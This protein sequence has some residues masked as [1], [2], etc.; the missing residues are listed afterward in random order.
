MALRVSLLLL[1]ASFALAQEGADA[2]PAVRTTPYPAR[3][4]GKK[5]ATVAIRKK[6]YS[7]PLPADWV[8]RDAEVANA[9][10]AWSVLLPGSTETAELLLVRDETLASP[11][12]APYYHKESQTWE[13]ETEI[14]PSPVPRLIVTR[15]GRDWMNSYVFFAFRNN[16]Y[17]FQLSCADE[18]FVEAEQD[19]IAAAQGFTAD[20]EIWPTVPKA[21][22][23]KTEG[24]WLIAKA[25]SAT[26]PLAPL[27]S[28]LK[29]AEKRFK[30]QHGTL[31][32]G[33]AP[34]V[35]LVHASLAEAK[36]VEPE[37]SDSSEGFYADVKHRRVFMLPVAKDNVEQQGRLAEA[38]HGILLM[39]KYGDTR[40]NWVW[41]GE[42]TVARAEA[43]TGKPL[44]SLDEGFFQWISKLKLHTLDEVEEMQRSDMLT[45]NLESFFYVAML[46]A[47]KHKKAYHE[48]L[49]EFGETGDGVA[50]G[51]RIRRIGQ[52]E[53]LTA[54]I[55][56]EKRKE[57]KPK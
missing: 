43:V 26:A 17:Y 42:C 2:P 40:P 3:E 47:G 10:L 39:A 5:P 19:I 20:I 11:R 12:A 15:P 33:E 8:V 14:R 28:G 31:A 21:Y 48:C 16:P 45:W 32:K 46:Q 51:R 34:I 52:E 1:A 4:P 41:V 36:K 37:V 22:E 18:D 13:G 7:F 6:V 53:L 54:T 9:E 25:P 55:K 24:I 44:P 38:A 49:A 30:R 35:V 56:S 23:T 57:K 29:D 27:I 50:F